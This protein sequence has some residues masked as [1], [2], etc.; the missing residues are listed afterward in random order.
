M[1]LQ[2]DSKI[3]MASNKKDKKNRLRLMVDIDGVVAYWE[4]AAAEI[5]GIDYEDT[6]VREKLKKGTRLETLV[7]GDEKMWPMINKGGEEWWE[8]LEKLPWADDLISLLK[9]ETKELIFLT[10]PSK[11]PIC[12][13]GKIKWILKNY[14]KMS[15]DVLMGCKKYM[16]AAPNV[17]LIDDTEKKVKEFKEYGGHTFKWP[18]PLSIIDGDVDVEDVFKDLKEA[19]KEVK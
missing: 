10:S 4:K 15:R 9:K 6:E 16:V 19:I 2:G 7:G 18:C 3:I 12:Y 5:C 8:N 17:L 13:S 1:K 11:S 14:P